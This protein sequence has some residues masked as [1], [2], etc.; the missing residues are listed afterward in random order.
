MPIVTIAEMTEAIKKTLVAHGKLPSDMAE[1]VAVQVLSYFGA[2]GSVLDNVLTADDRDIF[3]KLEEEGVL[4]SEVENTIV[5]KGKSW[6]IH[7]WLLNISTIRSLG[8]E[9][10]STSNGQGGVYDR[11]SQEEWTRTRTTPQR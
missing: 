3:Y 8:K 6:R 9:V 2:E 10:K 1:K 4:S 7:Y 5:E 11:L